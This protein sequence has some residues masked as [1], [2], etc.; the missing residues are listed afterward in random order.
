MEWGSHELYASDKGDA[1]CCPSHSG[2]GTSF[3]PDMVTYLG[4]FRDELDNTL[5]TY[6][7]YT[8]NRTFV[9][10]NGKWGDDPQP[11]IMH[12]TWYYPG[13]TSPNA[14]TDL[15]PNDP[16]KDANPLSIPSSSFVDPSPY[17]LAWNIIGG[18]CLNVTDMPWPPLPPLSTSEAAP[19]DVALKAFDPPT[20]M[21]TLTGPTYSNG[22]ITYVSG[23]TDVSFNVTQNP[24]AANQGAA[25]T[26]YQINPIGGTHPVGWTLAPPGPITLAPRMDGAYFVEFFSVDTLKNQEAGPHVIQLSLDTTPPVVTITQPAATNYPP[27]GTLTLNFAVGDGQGSGVK[28]VTPEMDGATTV[29]G[30]GLLSG[31]TINLAELALGSHTFSVYSVDNVGNYDTKSVTF[32]IA[33]SEATLSAS[34]LSFGNQLVGVSSVPQSVTLTNTGNATLNI[35]SVVASGDFAV[36]SQCG[37]SVGASAKCTIAVTYTPTSGGGG[38]GILTIQDD[39]PGS[40]HTVA[41]SGT[42]QDFSVS[43]ASGGSAS[44]TVSRGQSATY[45][46]SF[47]PVGGLTGTVSLACKGAPLWSTCV[48]SP[49]SIPL[50]GSSA[51]TATVTVTTTAGATMLPDPGNPLVPRGGFLGLRIWIWALLAALSALVFARRVGPR[52]EFGPARLSSGMPLLFVALTTI[53]TM[54][55]CN[56]KTN[57]TPPRPGH[58]SWQLQPDRDWYVHIRLGNTDTQRY[59]DLECE[60][61]V[62]VR[63]PRMPKLPKV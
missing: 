18:Q 59:A 49:A 40:P 10:F 14:C 12:R 5:S 2:N 9:F 52:K 3:L 63:R 42:G 34:S 7:L 51:S 44:A 47:L 17:H 8:A 32:S 57:N 26:Y 21:S 24:V 29:S 46:L 54:T 23:T 25:T 37:N 61:K 15:I 6:P 30:R 62:F 33:G 41:L 1:F 50:N 20:T 38:G 53:I 11:A 28:S 22:G 48:V 58:V 31:Q 39:A 56:R 55:S 60:V 43:V 13:N 19:C 45:N 36:K 27:N 16:E 35:S 4:T